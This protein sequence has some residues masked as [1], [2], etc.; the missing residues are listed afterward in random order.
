MKLA[1]S[2]VD[3]WGAGL[4]GLSVVW[5]VPGVLTVEGTGVLEAVDEAL[6]EVALVMLAVVAVAAVVALA[7]VVAAVDE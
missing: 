4:G 3:L 2:N 5:V 6:G 7:A 1:A